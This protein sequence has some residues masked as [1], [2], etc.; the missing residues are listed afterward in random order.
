MT[1]LGL[2]RRYSTPQGQLHSISS[3]ALPPCIAQSHLPASPPPAMPAAGGGGGGGGYSRPGGGHRRHGSI[4]GGAGA[5]PGYSAPNSPAKSFSSITS[6]S[7]AH[8]PVRSR[9]SMP[10]HAAG[11]S[12]VPG[13]AAALGPYSSSVNVSSPHLRSDSL[14]TMSPAAQQHMAGAASVSGS[15]LVPFTGSTGGGKSGQQ[16]GSAVVTYLPTGSENAHQATHA[17]SAG[18]TFDG[19]IGYEAGGRRKA[20]KAASRST[21]L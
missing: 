14:G 21:F 18:T 10:M 3:N 13:S 2:T 1:R 8:S 7:A 9:S 5:A 17:P 6:A 16:Q 12:G 19:A 15:S 4:G 20:A 11:S